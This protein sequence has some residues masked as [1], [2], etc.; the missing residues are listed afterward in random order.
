MARDAPKVRYEHLSVIR[1]PLCHQTFNITESRAS[2]EGDQ[3]LP[4]EIRMNVAY[5]PPVMLASGY[6]VY[7]I[8]CPKCSREFVG[9]WD[10]VNQSDLEKGEWMAKEFPERRHSERFERYFVPRRKPVGLTYADFMAEV[11][12]IGN[13]FVREKIKRE[14]TARNIVLPW[15]SVRAGPVPQE[16][17]ESTDQPPAEPE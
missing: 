12:A 6:E 11:E 4:P 1:C 3:A 16:G 5:A 15:G 13:K 17:R 8:T 9:R 7:L 14:L 10:V 2:F